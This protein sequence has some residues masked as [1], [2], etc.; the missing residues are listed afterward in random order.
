MK[1]IKK[2]LPFF[3]ARMMEMFIYR[4][5][6]WLWLLVDVFQ[7][8]MMIFLWNSVYEYKDVINGFT[9][10]EMLIYFLLTN[11]FF[12][13]T[14]VEAVFLISEEIREGRISLYMVKPI[15]YK[16]RLYFEILGRAIGIITLMIPV[17]FLTGLALTF[18]F[19]IIWTIS[20][21]QILLAILYIPFI[22]MLMFEFS[23]LFG[24]VAIYTTNVFGLVIFIS[25]FTRVVSGQL[26]PLALYPDALIG[27]INYMPF[28]FLS[29][30]PLI[31]LNKIGTHEI[32]VG[33]MILALWV[34]G[35][36]VINAIFYKLSIKKMVVFGG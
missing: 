10:N 33:L 18:I 17:V 14:Q 31:L 32:L 29:Y 12:V 3:K 30:P 27:V 5:A 23:F 20:I 6:V 11:L 16:I 22:F 4:G 7:F 26:I 35:F 21:W 19:H 1:R 8:V 34:I 36:M 2:Y 24:M 13:F 25:V 9:F 15:S 28:R